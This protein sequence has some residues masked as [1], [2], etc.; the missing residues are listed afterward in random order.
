MTQ[1][2]TAILRGSP[3]FSDAR[4]A[5]AA[6]TEGLEAAWLKNIKQGAAQAASGVTGSFAVAIS[7][8][9]DQAFLAV[10]RFSVESLCYRI[11]DGKLH[12]AARADQLAF[13]AE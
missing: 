5:D 6:R 11:V 1:L 4:L 2:V 7:T 3:Q 8:G 10:D 13:N 9:D 12:V